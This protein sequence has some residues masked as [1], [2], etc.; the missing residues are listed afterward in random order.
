MLGT[1]DSAHSRRT[2]GDPTAIPPGRS[3]DSRRAGDLGKHC[4][5]DQP[6]PFQRP[7]G[8]GQ[9]FGRDDV[10]VLTKFGEADG[11]VGHNW[12][13]RDAH[14]S[15]MRRKTTCDGHSGSMMSA[16]ARGQQQGSPISTSFLGNRRYPI[17]T[18]GSCGAYARSAMKIAVYGATGMV[19]GQIVKKSLRKGHDVT[20]VSRTGAP[21]RGATACSAELA[22]VACSPT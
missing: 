1:F 19:G 8:L 2:V 22:D 13:T 15:P 14:L 4:P 11:T 20:A 3:V 21:V 7:Q 18:K 17:D 12:T 9:N 6:V 5:G 10:N 16:L